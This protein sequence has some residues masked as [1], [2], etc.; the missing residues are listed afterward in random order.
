MRTLLTKEVLC[1]YILGIFCFEKLDHAIKRKT[2]K[3]CWCFYKSYGDN[4]PGC[5]LCGKVML[6]VNEISDAADS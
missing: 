5:R 3:E 2:I 1:V 4:R 6:I